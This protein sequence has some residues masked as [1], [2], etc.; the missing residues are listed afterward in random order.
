MREHITLLRRLSLAGAY[1][2]W[3]LLYAHLDKFQS[4]TI[5][6]KTITCDFEIFW[7]LRIRGHIS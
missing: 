7:V 1:T 5:E 4:D 2:K 6:F 3:S